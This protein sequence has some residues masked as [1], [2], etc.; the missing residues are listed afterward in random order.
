[1]FVRADLYAFY[2]FRKLR[3]PLHFCPLP[4][5]TCFFL[6]SFNFPSPPP[7]FLTI[8]KMSYST[9]AFQGF[10]LFLENKIPPSCPLGR[11]NIL[12]SFPLFPDLWIQARI[13]TH[14]NPPPYHL[15]FFIGDLDRYFFF[16]FFFF[17][18]PCDFSLKQKQTPKKSAVYH[19]FTRCLPSLY[20]TYHTL[21][22][23]PPPP[24]KA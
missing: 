6:S 2:F 24:Q 4:V 1:M 11:L 16:F 13:H 10:A 15:F 20:P 23:L 22:P 14:E 17:F 12:E 9:K 3:P 5:N 18:F 19:T 8:T 7:G 21:S